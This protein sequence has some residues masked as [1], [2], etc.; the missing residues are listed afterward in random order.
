MKE[1]NFII[2]MFIVIG[3]SC[4]N[5]E[6][7]KRID[8]ES[9]G[10]E[11][12]ANIDDPIE[13]EDPTEIDDP[14]E[15]NEQNEIEA[16]E[17][18]ECELYHYVFKPVDD[19]TVPRE[20]KL[21]KEILC[22]YLSDFLYLYFYLKAT[23]DEIVDFLDQT[24]LFEPVYA[25]SILRADYSLMTI[26]DYKRWENPVN[27]ALLCVKTKESK[28][29][30]QLNEIIRTLHMSS[31]VRLAK[32]TFCSP[33]ALDCLII[34]SFSPYFHVQVK[35]RNDLSDLYAVMEKTNTWIIDSIQDEFS[36][37]NGTWFL[38]AADKNSKGDGRQM[39]NYFYETGKFSSTFS[40][41]ETFY[42][43]YKCNILQ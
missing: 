27:A 42:P 43:G 24:D 30:A 1:R 35:D 41:R 33:T 9:T 18:C 13:N 16:C 20:Y 11:I 12:P 8:E 17:A 37:D 15:V 3:M 32:H 19:H 38:L 21:Q 22:D 25:D 2:L 34:I 26:P 14:L 28:T 31:I 5:Q 6:A 39:A 7:V 4:Q 29:Y 36:P 40:S 10:I 23:D